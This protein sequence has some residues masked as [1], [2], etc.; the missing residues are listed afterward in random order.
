[1]GTA[2][3]EETE[4]EPRKL[5]FRDAKSRLMRPEIDADGRFNSGYPGAAELGLLSEFDAQVL[6]TDGI[7][8]GGCR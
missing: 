7:G 2:K 1:L 3:G 6:W 8:D 4:T 5:W